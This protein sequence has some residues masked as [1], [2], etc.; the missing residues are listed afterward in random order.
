MTGEAR[1]IRSVCVAGAGIVGLSAALAFARALPGVRVSI[2]EMPADPAALTD[3]LPG[4]LPTIHLFH[5][6]I[7][8]DELE[9]VRAGAATHL[10]GTRFEN[11]SADGAPWYHVFDRYGMPAGD[12]DFH[13]V[14]Q[15]ARL[16]ERALRFHRYAAAATLAE[17][18]KFVHPSGDPASPLGSFLYALRLEPDRYR[19]RLE[20]AA[21]ALPRERGAITDIERR[22]DGG[23]GALLLEDGLRIEADLFID[24]AGP[25]APLLSAVDPGFEQW[26]EWLPCDRVV[27]DRDAGEDPNPCDL[28]VASD[29]GWR[30]R[31][32]RAYCSAFATGDG[33][34]EIIRP[35]RR[36]EPWVRNVL[37][38]GDAAVAIDPLHS[39]SLHLAQSA[40]LRALELLPG[41][42]CHPLELREYNRRTEQ[43][44]C[45]VRD[46][47][48]LHYLRSGRRDTPFWAA[49]AER[50]APAGLSRTLEQFER[51]GRLP[52]FEEESFD[53]QSWLAVLLGLGVMPREAEPVAAG[54]DLEQAAPAMDRLA[55]RLAAL[56]ERFPP[57]REVLAKMR[58]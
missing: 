36:P 23:I 14:W 7:G 3:R 28:A 58:A 48:A 10:L 44:T 8:L 27:L 31:S 43:E 5:A 6:A 13:P 51:R 4:S 29:D 53:R 41:R 54:V 2:L 55:A 30:W 11:W 37:A 46:F 21:S 50:S 47:L 33:G 19:E 17:A 52:F 1:A 38:L 49:M 40:I 39:T 32:G 26:D 42:D 34:G 16:A 35:G 57:Y 18:G 56:P 9:L 24:C 20:A 15:R 45:R 25:A 22:A 12:A